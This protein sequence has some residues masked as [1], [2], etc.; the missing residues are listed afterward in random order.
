MVIYVKSI[1]Y[2][3]TDINFLNYSGIRMNGLLLFY[4]LAAC[5]CD[6]PAQPPRILAVLLQQSIS[7]L[8]LIAQ[9]E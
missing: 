5:A 2:I 1:I 8:F 6:I 3:G 9:F 7:S 4:R